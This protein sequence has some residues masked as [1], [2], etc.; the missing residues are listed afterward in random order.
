MQLILCRA[1][2]DTDN[3]DIGPERRNYLDHRLSRVWEMNGQ[4][5]I[6]RHYNAKIDFRRQS[7]DLT[8]T[9]SLH[10]SQECIVPSL[11]ILRTT[12]CVTI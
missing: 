1:V 3:I 10:H 5:I 8:C 2:F 4:V 7:F 6:L 9:I 11:E 12:D